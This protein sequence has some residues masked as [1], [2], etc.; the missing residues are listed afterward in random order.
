MKDKQIVALVD[1]NNFFVS[2]ERIFRPELEGKPV[3]V[4]SSNDGCAVARSNEAKALGIPMGA[5]AFKYRQIFEDNQVIKFSANFELYGDISRRVTQILTSVTPRVEVYSIDEAFLD[6]GQLTID[7]YKSWGIVVREAV[8]SWVGIPI[9]IGIAPT[10][11]LA[12]IAVSVAKKDLMSIGVVDLVS[13]STK[14]LN[15]TLAEVDIA[16]VW[17]VG[18]RLAPKLRANGFMNAYQLSQ[19]PQAVAMSLMGISGAQMVAEL[20]GQPCWP[21]TLGTK[22]NQSIARTRT[23]GEDTSNF[24]VL[25]AAIVSFATRAAFRLRASRQLTRRASLFLVTNK[26]KPGYRGWSAEIKF[27]APTADSGK[28]ITRMVEKLKEI[29]SPAYSYHRA[30]VNLYD[31][32]PDDRLQLDILGDV[33]PAVFDKDSSRMRAVDLLNER[34]GSRGILYAAELLGS[35]WEPKHKLRSPRY[36]SDWNE[37]PK[38]SF[39]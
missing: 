34:F 31:F 37:L 27:R 32:V 24:E 14:T 25:E 30:G 35:S 33:D 22:P 15:K 11:T 36:V 21:I 18:R 28:I 29:Y 4:L 17:G 3:V 12:K 38:V 10:K 2:C 19:M 6:L 20:I 1:C 8:K 23:F 16:D 39:W 26:H 7:S 9:S 5:P 13:A